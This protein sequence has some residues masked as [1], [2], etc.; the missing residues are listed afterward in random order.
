VAQ[1]QLQQLDAARESYRRALALLEPL[2]DAR[3]LG[4]VL[5]NFGTLELAQRRRAVALALQE[6]AGALLR[7]AGDPRSDALARGRRAVALSVQGRLPDAER[8]SAHA[9]RMLRRDPLGRAVLTLLR[10]FIELGHARR[11]LETGALDQAGAELDAARARAE[12]AERDQLN[13]RR[14]S[15]QSDDLRLYLRVL[16][17]ELERVSAQ[18]AAAT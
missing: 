15:E 14:V 1:Q 18:L 2:G 13:G 12:Q 5:S 3:L 10:A 8:A 6:R 17:P 16:M 9:E 7:D 4:I 11:A